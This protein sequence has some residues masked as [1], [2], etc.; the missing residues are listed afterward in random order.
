MSFILT[1]F[2]G[3]RRSISSV[4]G[5]EVGGAKERRGDPYSTGCRGPAPPLRSA[6]RKRADGWREPEEGERRDEGE[7]KPRAGRNDRARHRRQEK[8]ARRPARQRE[9]GGA[10]CSASAAE[11]AERVTTSAVQARGPPA[12]A[13]RLPGRRGC[14]RSEATSAERFAPSQQPA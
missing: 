7:R 12:T 1:P 13:R 11:Q 5:Q 4:A 6:R 3:G 2:P 10:L 14:G 9:A 8:D